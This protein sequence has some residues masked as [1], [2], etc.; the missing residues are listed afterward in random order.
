MIAIKVKAVRK[1][2]GLFGR[3]GKKSR[4]KKPAG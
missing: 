3:S 4:V 1:G 2:G